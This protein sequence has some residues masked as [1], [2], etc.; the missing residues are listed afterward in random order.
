MEKKENIEKNNK[1]ILTYA[2]K[3]IRILGFFL[4]LGI[5]LYM[6]QCMYYP[7]YNDQDNGMYDQN[8]HAFYAEPE[9]TLDVVFMGNSEAYSA[10][11]PL[12]LWHEYGMTS[13]VCAKG[14]S[15]MAEIE[16][17]LTEFLKTQKPKVVVLETD[18][19]FAPYTTK[20][21]FDKNFQDEVETEIPIIRYH[22]RW[23]YT[24]PKQWFSPIDYSWKSPSKGQMIISV[25]EP[26]ESE[27]LDLPDGAGK[28]YLNGRIN[29]ITKYYVNRI[30]S[31]CEENGI[32]LILVSVPNTLTG[33]KKNYQALNKY[34]EQ[35]KVPLLDLQKEEASVGLDWTKDT[36]DGGVHL[37]TRGAR[38]VSLFVGERIKKNYD[39]P[40]R[41]GSDTLSDLWDMDYNDYKKVVGGYLK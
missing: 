40:D 15:S 18:V 14:A 12:E 28:D 41:R 4:I 37:N 35:I 30:K 13:F 20:K 25:S 36:R 3:G 10:F 2:L 31:I 5:L 34:A 16:Y 39:I 17:N 7:K 19:V 23:K 24:G 33:S 9:N 38:K 1:G 8:A 22:N 26:Y 6:L 11:S 21:L 32:S 27:K 29:P